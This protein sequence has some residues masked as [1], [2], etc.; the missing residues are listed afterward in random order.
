M[1]GKKERKT[2]SELMQGYD[3]IV[4]GKELNKNSKKLFE[5]TL[6]KAVKPRSSK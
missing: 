1:K 6:K 2:M 4:K 3:E 5:K